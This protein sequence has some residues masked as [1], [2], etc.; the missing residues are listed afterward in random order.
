MYGKKKIFEIREKLALACRI[1]YMEGL[2]DFNLG[3]ASSRVPDEENICIKPRGLGLEEIKPEDLI[4]VDMEGNL[5]EGDHSPHGET[6]IHTEI[7]K[8]RQDVVSIVHVHPVFSTAFSAVRSEMKPLN[9]DGVLFPHGIPTLESPELITTKPQGQALAQRL[10][11]GNAVFLRNHGIVTLG[12]RIEETCLTA[13]FLERALRVRSIASGFGEVE[14]ISE[15]TAL[16]MYAECQNP[17]RYD[18]I[19]NYL[20]RKLEREGLGFE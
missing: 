16:K 19:W 10:G 14:A 4:V 6:P 13:L 9:Q 3:H 12:T 8:I 1:L 2:E 5:L 7:Y 11:K 20:V 15:E 17:K 18:M